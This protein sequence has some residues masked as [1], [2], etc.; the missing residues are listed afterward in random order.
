MS[1][2]PRAAGTDPTKRTWRGNPANTTTTQHNLQ[3]CNRLSLESDHNPTFSIL[4]VLRSLMSMTAAPAAAVP[5][6]ETASALNVLAEVRLNN[7]PTAYK[8]LVRSK[9]APSTLST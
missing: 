4:S 7:A 1:R 2:R 9:G 6:V 8:T 5:T 3:L